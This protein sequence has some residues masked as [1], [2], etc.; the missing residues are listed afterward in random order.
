LSKIILKSNI[1]ARTYIVVVFLKWFSNN[2]IKN[3][4][5]FY[6]IKI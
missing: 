6:W 5:H 3:T 2:F 4:V 1:R